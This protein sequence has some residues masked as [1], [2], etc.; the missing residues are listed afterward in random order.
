MTA[1]QVAARLDDRFRLLTGGSRTALP[2]HQTLRA[3]VDW[4][5]DLLDEG[6]RALLRRLSVFAGGGT[7]EAIEQ[8]CAGV[9]VAGPAVAGPAEVAGSAVAV[10]GSAVAAGDVFDL[11]AALVD[12]SLL[13]VRHSQDGPRYRMLEIIRAYGRERLAEAGETEAVRR[14]HGAYFLR[15]AES[16]QEPLLTGAQLEWLPKLA[17][18]QDNLHAAVRAAVAAR[19]AATAA[20]LIGAS[21]LYWW[22]RNKEEGGELA[23]E[24][25]RV[26]GELTEAE[27][28]EVFAG[29]GAQDRL[30]MAY[31]MGG[32][33]NFDS[34]RSELA[35]D[36]LLTAHSF[37][38]RIVREGGD[39]NPLLFLTEP[40]ARLVSG[41]AATFP[42][43]FDE[44]V[45]S[46]H[47]WVSA[48]S[49]ILRG[50]VELNVGAVEAAEADFLAAAGTFGG[51]G[52]RW[53]TAVALTNLA[54]LA[55]WRGE[56]AAA[57]DYHERAIAGVTELGSV[58]DEIQARL[59]LARDLWLTGGE[60]E[61]ER[62]RAEL[63]AALRGADELGWPEVTANAAYTAGNLARMDGDLDAARRYLA[64]A[65]DIARRPGLPG[66]LVALVASSLGYL[67]AETGDLDAA[68]RCHQHAIDTA[69]RTNDGPAVAQVVAGLADL[70]LHEG[71]PVLA[72]TLLGASEGVRGTTDRSISDEFRVAEAVRGALTPADWDAAFQRG[73]GATLATLDAVLTPGAGTRGPRAARTPR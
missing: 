38:A 61:R 72:A 11:L 54:T 25:L 58:E 30:A 17:A 66:Q 9:P 6:E 73:R 14:A 15:L 7:L 50:Q 70:A 1:E 55:V 42:D 49:R 45:G 8:V 64:R 63:A 2:R 47:P 56:Y 28:G 22:M 29:Q 68:R 52:E 40:L 53:G 46:P 65:Q 20:G 36:W 59:N 69:R 3:V 43:A 23:I 71:D 32:M 62:S 33:L 41:A 10:A 60:T 67:A 12:K 4:S 26:V 18:E 34:P 35:V 21:G 51:L 24:A 13:V 5:W 19:D 16:G 31:A 48:I 39:C 44:A 27:R 57:A 37:I